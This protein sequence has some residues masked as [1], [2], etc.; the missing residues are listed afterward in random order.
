LILTLMIFCAALVRM[1]YKSQNEVHRSGDP[2]PPPPKVWESF[3]FL[4]RY[5]GGIRTLMPFAENKPE[6]PRGEDESPR[7][8]AT[9]AHKLASRTLPSSKTFNPYP[10]YHSDAYT[11]E[12]GLVKKCY[13]DKAATIQIPSLQYYEGRTSGFPD[14]VLGDYDILGLQKDICF[15]RYGRLGPYGHGYGVRL[16]GLGSG[17]NGDREG[18]DDIWRDLPQADYRK[19]DWG[20]AQGRC[21]DA[22]AGRFSSASP[23][24]IKGVATSEEI[25]QVEEAMPETE[26]P[27]IDTNI[28]TVHNTSAS[29]AGRDASPKKKLHRTA[30]V[31]RTWDT[32]AYGEDDILYLRALIAELSLG[33]AGEYDVHLLV[34]VKDETVPIWADDDA[35]QEHLQKSVP[36]EFWGMATLWSESQMLMIYKSLSKDERFIR[37]PDLPNH[38]VYRGLMLAFQYFAHN[39]PE[40]EYF[41]HLEMDF[42]STAHFYDLFSK[43][44]TWSAR[45]PR[46][47]L[48]ERNSRYYIPSLH[49]SWADFS[50]MVRVQTEHGTDS[51]NNIWS[52]IDATKKAAHVHT[53]DKSVWGPERPDDEKDWFEIESDPVPPTSYGRDKYE[54]GVGEEA[55]L[56]TLNPIFDPDGTTW[57]LRDDVSGYDT[58]SAY[59]PRR[60]AIITTSRLSRRLLNVMHRETA[61]RGHHAFSE[62]WPATAA[63]HHGLKAVYVP[64]P[65]FVDREWPLPFLGA[66]LNAGRNGASGGARMS[67]FG[68][69]EHNLL[70]ATWYYNANFA[71][72]L[73]KRWLG[74]RVDGDGGESWELSMELEGKARRGG[75]GEG[76]MCLPPMILHP[77]KGVELPVESVR[78][79]DV[80][81]VEKGESDP[82]A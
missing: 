66:T 15:E 54:W 43:M 26:P 80:E 63:L 35:Y 70:G 82:S 58:S 36:E 16:G 10:D 11:Q 3:P 29:I 75:E 39:H 21:F 55:D 61:H 17:Y 64:H 49:G 5:Y 56:I 37:G 2:P 77:V 81:E 48:W 18:I 1:G 79:E 68:E 9:E 27:K 67:V 72:R 44:S 51:P 40:Y 46:K 42:R 31:V 57:L 34:Q 6:Y 69:R 23:Y 50:Q 59:P 52:G 73:W 20:A 60:A 28:T 71:G 78:L 30:V 33:S 19:V 12:F 13:L 38:G 25:G 41:W 74:L 7:T 4:T 24:S 14:N 22:N 62:M 47:G 32:Y 45:Q 8:N 65:M 76:R 53:A